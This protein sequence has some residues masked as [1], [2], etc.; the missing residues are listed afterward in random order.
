MTTTREAVFN[1]RA[2]FGNPVPCCSPVDLHT[3]GERAVRTVCGCQHAPNLDC[4]CVVPPP[5]PPP[6]FWDQVV[7]IP[8]DAWIAADTLLTLNALIAERDTVGKP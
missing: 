6:S 4:P 7:G 5:P 3:F 2:A 1:L 8:L